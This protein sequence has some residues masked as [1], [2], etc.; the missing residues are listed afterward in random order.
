MR[1]KNIETQFSQVCKSIIGIRTNPDIIAVTQLKR[2]RPGISLIV[3]AASDQ[4][5]SK[6]PLWDNHFNLRKYWL[7]HHP[8]HFDGFNVS[9]KP[10]KAWW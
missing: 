6:R 10:A 3:F 7:V 1:V 8:F 5:L 2:R 9:T 4:P